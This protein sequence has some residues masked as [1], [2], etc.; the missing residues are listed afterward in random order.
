MQNV[1]IGCGGVFHPLYIIIE[2]VGFVFPI[3]LLK[4]PIS[5]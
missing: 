2:V 5:I 3:P 4:I 1:D